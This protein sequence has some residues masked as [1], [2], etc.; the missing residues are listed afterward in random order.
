MTHEVGYVHFTARCNTRAFV[1][2]II[3]RIG[4]LVIIKRI[5][6]LPYVTPFCKK[7]Y[8]LCYS[9]RT[10]YL[11]WRN[12]IKRI[13]KK[14]RPRDTSGIEGRSPGQR[15]SAAPPWIQRRTDRDG[16][17]GSLHGG[18]LKETSG[19]WMRGRGGDLHGGLLRGHQ[20]RPA[21]PAN[22]GRRNETKGWCLYGGL[23]GENM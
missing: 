18:S 8:S 2:V 14:Q 12:K 9:T 10:T 17:G 19:G 1:L 21:D 20:Q 3:K 22:T 5:G 16:R 7:T 23:P 15:I 13:I 11:P 6:F 4:L